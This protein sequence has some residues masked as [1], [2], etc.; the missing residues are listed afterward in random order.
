MGRIIKVKPKLSDKIESLGYIKTGLN[1]IDEMVYKKVV[2]T[3]YGPQV[4]IKEYFITYDVDNEFITGWAFE[5]KQNKIST[6]R[7][8]DFILEGFELLKKDLLELGIKED[9]ID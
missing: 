3:N 7:Q 6:Q 4:L 9:S 1:F 2:K 5:H 8:I